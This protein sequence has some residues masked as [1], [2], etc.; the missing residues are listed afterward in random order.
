VVQQI[1]HNIQN[2]CVPT[3]EKLDAFVSRLMA[4]TERHVRRAPKKRRH[5]LQVLLSR[6]NFARHENQRVTTPEELK[7][8]L[9]SVIEDLLR[10]ISGG[11]STCPS[12]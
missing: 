10:D 7:T 11:S 9:N 3:A 6:R 1:E 8:T 2:H 5:A 12:S 4:N